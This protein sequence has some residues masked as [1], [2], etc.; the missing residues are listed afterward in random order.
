V[1]SADDGGFINLWDI[2]TGQLMSKFQATENTPD[3]RKITTACF[4]A[5]Q[6]RMITASQGGYIKIWNFS[7]G[8][9]LKTVERDWGEGPGKEVWRSEIDKEITSLVCVYN[10]EKINAEPPESDQNIS[11]TAVGWDRRVRTWVD[12]QVG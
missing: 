5:V 10:P 11:F 4:D 2:E 6:R 7:N 9:I 3:K 12:N 1:V 8:S